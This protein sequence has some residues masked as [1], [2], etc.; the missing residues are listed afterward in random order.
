MRK[1]GNQKVIRRIADRTRQ[2]AKGK[3]VIAV[4][5]IALTSLLFTTVFTVGGS[6][7][8]KQ[9]KST[10]R[11]VGT[12]SHAG[13]KYLTQ[14]EYDIV[15]KDKKIKEVSSRKVVAEAVNKELN[16]LRTEVCCFEEQDAKW[17]FCYPEK[18]HMPERRNEIVLSDLVLEALGIP[19]KIGAEVPLA[20]DVG[21]VRREE[22]FILCGY[23]KG[24][25][26][27]QAQMAAV[28][29]KYA[30][31]TAP[32]PT[33]SAMGGGID[34]TGYT[35]R[36]MADFNFRTS[37]N[38]EKQARDLAVRCGFPETINM[39]VNWAYASV[40]VD[41]ETAVFIGAL[42]LIILMSGY[43]IILYK[44]ISGY[45]VL[46][47]V[48][49]R[50]NNR[51]AV[52]ENRAAAG[53]YAFAAWYPH[54]AAGRSGSREIYPPHINEEAVVRLFKDRCGCGTQHMDI[55]RSGMF[56]FRDSLYQL[57][58]AVPDGLE[59]VPGGGGAVHRGAADSRQR[60]CGEKTRRKRKKDKACVS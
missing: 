9:Q 36:I 7:M 35:G 15:K 18:G 34:S 54:R 17:S 50:G 55:C 1:V 3:N 10:M 6:I 49:N 37:M 21:G 11:Q 29:A 23:Y 42:L 30:D 60:Q 32:T 57:C 33:E 27:S 28:S 22:S 59:S 39:G 38:L 24:D 40:D 58:K 5:A 20:L 2:A 44:R 56:L 47:S 13:F 16:K 19:C 14:A 25:R 45:P 46:R 51:K 4:L 52:K 12:S 43:L 41:A 8:D 31:E 53:V 26:I 48:K